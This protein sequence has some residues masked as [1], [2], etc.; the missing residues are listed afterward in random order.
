MK[1]V[2]DADA[3]DQYRNKELVLFNI[4]RFDYAIRKRFTFHEEMAGFHQIGTIEFYQKLAMLFE[5]TASEY[6][7]STVVYSEPIFLF[8][9][10]ND[11]HQEYLAL[12][13]QPGSVNYHIQGHN[14]G[15][16][17]VYEII[18]LYNADLK[19]CVFA[20]RYEDKI[21]MAWN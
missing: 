21:I 19:W 2:T 7:I 4:E 8:N 15:L 9:F 17:T 20:D 3:K 1:I 16:A 6:C 5:A 14:V 11:T 18:L 12:M 10:K 13:N